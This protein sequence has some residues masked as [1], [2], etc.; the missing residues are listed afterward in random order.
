MIRI[1]AVLECLEFIPKRSMIS[2]E[3]IAEIAG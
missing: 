2:C 1:G 3:D